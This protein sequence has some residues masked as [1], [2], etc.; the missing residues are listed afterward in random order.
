[1]KEQPTEETQVEETTEVKPPTFN[2]ILL[3]NEF[4]EENAELL[5]K[6]MDKNGKLVV[7][8]SLP[9]AFEL[10][11]MGNQ[12]LEVISLYNSTKQAQKSARNSGDHAKADQ[13]FKTMKDAQLLAAII[14]AEF[15]G[16]KKIADEIALVRVKQAEDNR[17]K[18]LRKIE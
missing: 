11:I 4:E 17:E 5:K 13:L 15:P 1:M 9:N 14:Q 2:D 18:A 7:D 3:K 8:T 10:E 16:A 6:V 12:L